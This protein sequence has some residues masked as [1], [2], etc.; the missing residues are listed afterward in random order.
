MSLTTP[1]I[2]NSFLSRIPHR[3]IRRLP[4]GSS[5]PILAIAD[6]LRIILLV[7]APKSFEKS[8]PATN[9]HFV[10]LPY[11]EVT[12]MVLNEKG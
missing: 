7:S 12:K 6:S 9:Y 1:M 2:V 5:R 3:D 4:I 10:V 8:R 11:S